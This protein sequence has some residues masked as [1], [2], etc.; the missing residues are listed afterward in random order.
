M[1]IPRMSDKEIASDI[2]AS[3]QHLQTDTIDLYWLH[4]DDPSRPAGEII[5]ALNSHIKAGKLR[6]IGCSNWRAARIAEAQSYAMAH[7]L[8]GF[9]ANQ[10]MWSLAGI[11]TANLPDKTLVAMDQELYAYHLSTGLAAIP[12]SSQAQGLFNKLAAGKLASI[13]KP[14]QAVD[15][16]KRL[17]RILSLQAETGFSITQTG[18]AYLT[19]QP[20]TTVPIVGCKNMTQLK[21]SLSAGDVT[22]TAQQVRFLSNMNV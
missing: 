19:S 16:E 2:D 12:F 10:M 21:D 4:R 15:N 14:Y 9:S 11:N 3:L 7:G 13:P 17:S 5:E 1:H 22:L 20:F 6:F 18:L 8:K